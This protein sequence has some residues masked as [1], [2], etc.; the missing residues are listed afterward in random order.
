MI[1]YHGTPI[2]GS[3]VDVS[4]FLSGRHGLVSFAAPGDMP[5]VAD[6]CQSFI[7][8]NGAF[9]AWKRGRDLDV[10]GYY[11]FVEQWHRH[12]GCDWALIP[13]VIDGD[14]A[15]NDAYIAQWP[16]SLHR[17]GVPVWHLHESIERLRAL[18]GRFPVVALG[19]SGQ[20]P[21]PGKGDWWMRMSQVMDAVCDSNGRPFCKLHGLRM[22][23]PRIFQILPLHSADSTNAAINGMRENRFGM[24]RPPTQA[25]RCDVIA[26]RIEAHNSAA[27]WTGHTQDVFSFDQ[28][29][30]EAA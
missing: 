5:I 11:Q 28:D 4:R 12:P 7:L 20:W 24:Y 15:A 21:N 2:G 22:L 6:V 17:V 19:S 8:D 13:D 16:Q 14:E 10:P 1:H 27:C 25:Q 29:A 18:V 3:R 9:S 26:S 23:D 30:P